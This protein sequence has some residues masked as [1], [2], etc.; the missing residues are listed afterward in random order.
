VRDA[1][2]QDL[3]GRSVLHEDNTRGLDFE[4]VRLRLQKQAERV[5]GTNAPEGIHVVKVFR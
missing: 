1:F 3:N 5:L 4:M 2:L